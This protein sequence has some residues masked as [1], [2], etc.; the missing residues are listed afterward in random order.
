[1][2]TLQ[3]ETREMFNVTLLMTLAW[4]R[5]HFR[6]D[7]DL[8]HG[9]CRLIRFLGSR[10]GNDYVNQ[11][12]EGGRY[13]AMTA[14][15][16][17]GEDCQVRAL[18]EAGCHVSAQD[19]YGQ[20]ALH[21]AAMTG[22]QTLVRWLVLNGADIAAH[23]S[24]PGK[25]QPLHLIAPDSGEDGCQVYQWMKDRQKA[26]EKVVKRWTK[27]FFTREENFPKDLR[28]KPISPLST[29]HVWPLYERPNGE[30]NQSR[31]EVKDLNE[32]MSAASHRSTEEGAEPGD[33]AVFMMVFLAKYGK[34]EISSAADSPDLL[35]RQWTDKE[36]ENTKMEDVHINGFAEN[37]LTPPSVLLKEEEVKEGG[38]YVAWMVTTKHMNSGMNLFKML[39]S[40]AGTSHRNVDGTVLFYQ[41]WICKTIPRESEEGSSSQAVTM[42]ENF[43]VV[44]IS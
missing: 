14:A 11:A 43:S 21:H 27:D 36:A 3:K 30:A 25:T 5:R 28:I 10:M 24:T 13:C 1:M 29:V 22:S 37:V 23:D 15:V 9:Y 16:R 32:Q 2:R 40:G 26:L 34:G 42:E 12:T 41:P 44:N 19:E 38:W 17:Q 7:S 33:V 18:L 35:R 8:Q 6:C 20:T 31:F 39:L 4:C